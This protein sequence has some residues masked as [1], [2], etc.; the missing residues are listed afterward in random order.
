MAVTCA[1]ASTGGQVQTAAK[2]STTAPY[3][4]V[5]MVA[6]AMTGW[7]RTIANVPGAKQVSSQHVFVNLF[8][9]FG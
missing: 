5:T 4:H 8:F 1:S 2:T 6:P 3:D 7:G 9:F